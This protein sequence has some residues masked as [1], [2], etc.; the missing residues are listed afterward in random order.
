MKINHRLGFAVFLME[1]VSTLDYRPE[2]GA[3]GRSDNPGVKIKITD[4]GTRYLAKLSGD[5]IKDAIYKLDISDVE[6]DLPFRV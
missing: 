5:I 2:V 6:T 3:N 1:I 4:K